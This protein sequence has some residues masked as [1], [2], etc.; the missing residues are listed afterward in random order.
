MNICSKCV[1]ERRQWHHATSL[2]GVVNEIV[3]RR[4]ILR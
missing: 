1:C 4:E 3:Y 2:S